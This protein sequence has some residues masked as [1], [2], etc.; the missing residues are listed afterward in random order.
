MSQ[1]DYI[2]RYSNFE[3]IRSKIA[4]ILADELASQ[5]TLNQAALAAEEAKPTPEQALIDFYTL[6]IDC[7]PSKVWEERFFR[8]QPSEMPAINIVLL[9]V[10]LVEAISHTQ[11]MGENKYQIEIYQSAKSKDNQDGDVL[12]SFKLHRL[13]EIIRA[14]LMNRNYVDL[15][16]SGIIGYRQVRDIVIGVPNIGADN[17]QSMIY[18]KLDLIVKSNETVEDLSGVELQLHATTMQIDESGKGYYWEIE[19]A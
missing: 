14:I 5:K 17:A 2:L 8:F 13:L 19:A 16:L 18:G 4:A 10:P 9:N 7:I 11:Q 15:G 6:N 12:A 3:I 1:I